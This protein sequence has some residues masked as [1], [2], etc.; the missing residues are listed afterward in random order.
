MVF[1]WKTQLDEQKPALEG[2]LSPAPVLLVALQ[3]S[4]H[5]LAFPRGQQSGA[6]LA[7]AVN[8]LGAVPAAVLAWS[9]ITPGI[10]REIAKSG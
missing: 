1:E 9:L 2:S 5:C 4:W 8:G 3:C 10:P 6:G 7:K